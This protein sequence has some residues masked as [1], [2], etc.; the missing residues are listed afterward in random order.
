MRPRE[1]QIE[2]SVG[3]FLLES[4]LLEFN[5]EVCFQFQQTSMHGYIE[6]FMSLYQVRLNLSFTPHW[7]F[8]LSSSDRGVL[9]PSPDIRI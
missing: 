7:P 6:K 4:Q 9:S 8:A 1:M 3:K 5:A 2:R